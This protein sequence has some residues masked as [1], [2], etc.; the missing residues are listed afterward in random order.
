[1]TWA[2]ERAEDS[3]ER[4][5]GQ[6]AGGGL[7]DDPEGLAAG[8]RQED[9]ALQDERHG[10]PVLLGESPVHRGDRGGA[11][12]RFTGVTTGCTIAGASQVL[13]GPMR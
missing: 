10:L 3:E 4:G 1:M 5:E 12:T 6:A 11:A 2:D 9:P 13:G 7:L 8:Y